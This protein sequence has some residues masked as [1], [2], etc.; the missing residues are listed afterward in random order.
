MERI[1]KATEIYTLIF[2]FLGN[3]YGCKFFEVSDLFQ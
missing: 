2:S 1:S 3:M